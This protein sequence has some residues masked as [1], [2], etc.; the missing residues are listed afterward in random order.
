[1]KSF[2]YHL[3]A[4]GS[5]AI[6]F[7]AIQCTCSEGQETGAIAPVPVKKF[8]GVVDRAHKKIN[9]YSLPITK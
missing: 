4:S 1:V 6:I 7:Q 5:K 9:F 3:F 8:E 2:S